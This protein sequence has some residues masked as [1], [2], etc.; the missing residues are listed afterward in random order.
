MISVIFS[1]RKDNKPHIDHLKKSSGLNNIEILQ[2][3]N[4]GEF[5][6]T[7]IYNKGLIESKNDIVVFCHDDIIFNKEKWG[8]KLINHFKKSD[9]AILGIAGTT[10]MSSSGKWWEDNT[11]MMGI[12]KHSNNGKTWESKYCSNFED[13]ILESVVLDGLFF[14]CH[15]DRI[16]SNFDENFKGFHF[17]DI[18][19][20]FSNHL[21]GSKV[22][23]IFDIK[24]THM[25]IGETNDVWEKN[26]I[27]FVEK[28]KNSL[29]H[30]IK[31][32]I[33]IDEKIFSRKLKETPK[34]SI[35]IPTKGNIDL[36]KQCINSI[37][38]YDGY[39]MFKIYI[40]DTGSTDEEKNEI[41]N[42]ISK[43]NECV[44]IEYDYYNF[45]SINNDVV[46]N[47]I[48]KDTELILFC[49]NDIKLI[50]EAITRMVDVYLNNKKT[51]GT[52]GCRLHYSNN[53]IQHSGIITYISM[54]GRQIN[55]K[56]LVNIHLNHYGIRSYYNYHRG[57]NKN[58]FGNTAAFMM[59]PTELF[60]SIGG[61]NTSYNEC[62]E[63][64]QLN[65]DCLKRGKN[66]I[67]VGDAVCYHY[68]SQTRNKS[69]EKL[70][71]ESEDYTK[72]IIPYIIN[73]NVT[74]DYFSNIKRK[75]IENLMKNG[76]TTN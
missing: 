17:Y 55:G 38:D 62:F 58:V 35:I 3:V 19:F 31:P 42:F 57:I 41:K 74:Y 33:I 64:V 60:K 29:P 70:K 69:D 10:D 51:V 56:N 15:K 34:I 66:N 18:D 63:D 7:E 2:Y 37:Y 52:I 49:N 46:N 39:T 30:N 45:A 8:K 59:I 6:L 12:V 54:N 68:E 71:R 61:F 27:Q 4:N 9:Y 43:L 28:F 5:S 50:N 25:S 72:R 40:A 26:R 14:A 65:I 13:E 76:T 36:L 22:G 67:F 32:E 47:H 11:K 48:D 44:L 16:K 23:V 21:L 20:T 73:N 53:T 24:V 1:T 75:D